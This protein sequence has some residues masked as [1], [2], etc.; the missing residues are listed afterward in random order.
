MSCIK[1]AANV[2]LNNTLHRL[3][4]CMSFFYL[5]NTKEDT[6]KNDGNLTI[7]GSHWLEL[8]SILYKSMSTVNCLVAHSLQYIFLCVQ[9][10][11]ETHTG[12]EQLEAVLLIMNSFSLFIFNVDTDY[13]H[14]SFSDVTLTRLRC[15]VLPDCIRYFSFSV[16]TFLRLKL[17]LVT[18]TQSFQWHF[19]S[20][21]Q[22]LICTP[23]SEHI[24]RGATAL[25]YHSNSRQW[26]ALLHVAH[27]FRW[28]IKDK[29]IKLWLL[30][31]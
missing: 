25:F 23:P 1:K 13:I 8:F 31:I 2:I 11:T 7:A 20:L 18:V 3:H 24:L 4:A 28:H 27:A 5:L 6:L 26:N 16:L 21:L 19:S 30:V 17:S 15:V 10:K 14:H 12:L 29:L 22:Q 9:Q